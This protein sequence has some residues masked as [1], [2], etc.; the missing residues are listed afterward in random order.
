MLRPM[1][2]ADPVGLA[3]IAER[4][5]VQRQT[6]KDWKQRGLLPPPQWTVSR[7]PAWDWP[8]IEKWARRTG[9]LGDTGPRGLRKPAAR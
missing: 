6:A 8:D 1:P 9:R 7:A 2:K 4:L 5:G 3:E